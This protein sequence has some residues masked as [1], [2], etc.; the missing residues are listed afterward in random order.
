MFI[1]FLPRMSFLQGNF[2]D[3]YSHIWEIWCQK[4]VP[5]VWTSNCMPQN[6]VKFN[7]SSMPEIPASGTKVLIYVA[8]DYF[9]SF[10][11]YKTWLVTNRQLRGKCFHLMTSSWVHRIHAWDFMITKTYGKVHVEGVEILMAIT[12]RRMT[13]VRVAVPTAANDQQDHKQHDKNDSNDGTNRQPATRSTTYENLKR[14]I[15]VLNATSD[16]YII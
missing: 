2:C 12:C 7:T 3:V 14:I 16:S 6:T 1:I 8:I 15:C 10:N 9:V 4:H 11:L 13:I 5:Y